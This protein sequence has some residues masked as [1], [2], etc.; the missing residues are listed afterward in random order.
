MP[1]DFALTK[2]LS[3][4]V[5]LKTRASARFETIRNAVY[6]FVTSFDRLFFPSVLTGWEDT[7]ELLASV[8][9]I[10][11]CETPSPKPLLA[12]K[13]MAIQVHVYQ[14][15]NSD[16]F[17]EYSNASGPRNDEDD[18]MA[19]T[20]CELPN[21]VYEGLW[22]SLVYAGNIKLKLLDYIHATL[23]LSDA[24]VDCEFHLILATNC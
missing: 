5:R 11:L 1:L 21:R 14:P 18:S 22:D 23:L 2:L 6:A 10:V 16:A 4:E 12:A 24:N 7:P 8:E 19:A 20:V 17:E 15:S 9:Q 3:V 13:E